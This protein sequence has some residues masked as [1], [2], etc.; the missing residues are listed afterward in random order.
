MELAVERRQ[1]FVV[2]VKA[3]IAGAVLTPLQ[4]AFTASAA[5]SYI[6]GGP[7]YRL[8]AFETWCGAGVPVVRAMA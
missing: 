1:W 8:A 3:Q 5:G 6:P 2:A 4:P 7:V